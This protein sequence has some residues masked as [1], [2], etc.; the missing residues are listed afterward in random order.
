MKREPKSINPC[1][2]AK[3]YIKETDGTV[4]TTGVITAIRD[5]PTKYDKKNKQGESE[6]KTVLT[7]NENTADKDQILKDVFMNNFSLTCLCESFGSDDKNWMGKQIKITKE[8]DKTFNNIMLV[9]RE[10]VEEV[11]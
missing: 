7:F 5:I 3:D 10:N 4:I 6:E 2:K 8:T 9:I 11:E 1:L